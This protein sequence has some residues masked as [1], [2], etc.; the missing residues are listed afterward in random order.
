MKEE[1]KK[2][3]IRKI[4]EVGLVCMDAQVVH[5]SQEHSLTGKYNLE[6][7]P[8]STG[9]AMAPST[10]LHLA[11]G[12]PLGRLVPPYLERKTG[13]ASTFLVLVQ[14]LE[15]LPKEKRLFLSPPFLRPL[16]YAKA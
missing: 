16:T 6:P 15:L 7:S 3:L 12:G 1:K 4:H 5:C 2:N 10:M 8:C 14:S 9:Q 13:M 11:R